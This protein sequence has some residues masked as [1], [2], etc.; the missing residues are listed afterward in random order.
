[1]LKTLE[2]P[3][4][5]TDAIA[6]LS[7]SPQGNYLIAECF[8][9]TIIIINIKTRKSYKIKGKAIVWASNEN[10]FKINNSKD[11]EGFFSQTYILYTF[12]EKGDLYKLFESDADNT[13][14]LISPDSKYIVDDY[15]LFNG[16]IGFRLLD[17]QNYNVIV[18]KEFHNNNY[19]FSNIWSNNKLVNIAATEYVQVID[20]EPII[21]FNNF[22]FTLEQ[23]VLLQGIEM[24][25]QQDKKYELNAYWQS[26]FNGIDMG[27]KSINELLKSLVT[28]KDTPL[29]PQ[30]LLAAVNSVVEALIFYKYLEYRIQYVFFNKV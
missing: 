23:L 11:I 24:A 12:D 27:E 17:A 6:Y 21:N 16:G 28:T 4:E 2:K 26:V 29:S 5:M 10:F 22:P 8:D 20:F 18:K 3:T 25:A 14:I 9:G 7:W 15:S 19:I 30:D 1:M 13:F